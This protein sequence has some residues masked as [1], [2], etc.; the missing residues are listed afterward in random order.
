MR[1]DLHIHTTFSDGELTPDEVAQR[2]ADA[3]LN[4]FAITDHD[5]CAGFLALKP[6]KGVKAIAGIE[7][8]ADMG[9]E[10]HV[11]GYGINCDSGSL[12]KHVERAANSRLVRACEIIERLRRDGFE[13]SID[14]VRDA[15]GGDVIGRPHIAAVLVKKGYVSSVA[16]AFDAFLGSCAPYYVPQNK[17]TVARAAALIQEAGGR[18]VLAHPGLISGSSLTRLMPQLKEMGFWGVEAYHPAHTDGQCIEFV[19]LARQQGLY[20]TAG[21]D[22]HG[23]ATPRVQIGEERRTSR[24]LE[25][26]LFVLIN[27]C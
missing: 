27:K 19:S 1:A 14:D 16:E 17:I 26:S 21:S 11:L 12:V 2:A 7:L 3:K 23:S 20:V 22:F 18:A 9:G 4:A 24:Y 8:A 15:C 6:V 13:I 25:E 10:V 5:E